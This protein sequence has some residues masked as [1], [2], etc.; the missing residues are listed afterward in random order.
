MVIPKQ[1]LKSEFRFCLIKP[2]SKAPY[3]YNW[4]NRCNYI[5]N[6]IKITDHKGNLG[7]VCGYGGLVVLD[8]DNKDYVEEFDNELNTFSVETGS[9]GR[10]YYFICGEDFLQSIYVLSVG[11][12]R[13]KNSQVL[14][15][16]STH[17]NG[18]KYKVLND[19]EI[20]QVTKDYLKKILLKFIKKNNNCDTS[21]S[22]EDWGE[23]CSMIEGGY[24]FDEVDAEMKLIGTSRWNKEC[25]NYKISTYCNALKRI[26]ENE[27][28]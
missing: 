15:P 24:N 5:F 11:E 19:I 10:H 20:K 23:V 1:L 28:K 9:G 2:Q 18:N 13:V 26:K 7:I 22:G 14:I 21:R 8:I 4:Q 17:P 27:K 25:L 3:E 12:L 6:D 16:P